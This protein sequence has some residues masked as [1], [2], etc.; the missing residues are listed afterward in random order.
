MRVRLTIVNTELRRS[1]AIDESLP[2]GFVLIEAGDAS[3]AQIEQGTGSLSL[4]SAEF[5]PG[6]YQYHYLLRALVA[7]QYRAAATSARQPGGDLIGAGKPATLLV[8][9][10]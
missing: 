7:G 6:I 4:S 8:S 2:S 10:R 5:V 9:D 3:F 1:I